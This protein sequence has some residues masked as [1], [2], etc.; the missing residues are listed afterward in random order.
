MND[1]RRS[2][3]IENTTVLSWISEARKGMQSALVVLL[4]KMS[5]IIRKN[6]CV[7]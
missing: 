3:T 5:Y 4:K 1:V 6:D 2:H 7:E